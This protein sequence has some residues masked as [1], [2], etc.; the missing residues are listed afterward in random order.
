MLSK[1]SAKAFFLGG[2]GLCAVAFVML[3]A[4]TLKQFPERSHE[5]NL[6]PEVIHGWH[7]WERNNCMGCHTLLGEGGYYAPELTQVIARRG[8]GWIRAFLKDPQAFFPGRRKMIKYD[9]FDPAVDPEAEQNVSDI[10]AFFQWTS[11]IDTN[12]FPPEPNIVT[13]QAKAMPVATDVTDGI[14]PIAL[15]PVY[16]K[17]VCIGCHAVGGKGGNVGPALDGVATRYDRDYLTKWIGNPQSVKPGT[18]MPTLGL[19]DAT[20]TPIV[21]FLETLK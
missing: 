5:E 13:Q 1:S 20:L 21:D 10:L 17:T 19:D 7:I 14:D 18:A 11:E 3:T 4:D 12:G 2:T 16:F 15:A 8:E 9:F 6:S